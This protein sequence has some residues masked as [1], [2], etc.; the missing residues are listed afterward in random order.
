MKDPIRKGAWIASTKKHL[1]RLQYSP[2]VAEFPATEI[3][4]K[5]ANLLALLQADEA[6]RLSVESLKAYF[7]AAKIRAG[8]RETVLRKLHEEERIEVLKAGDRIEGVEV[9]TFSR[10]EVLNTAARIFDGADPT[11]REVA[12]I[13]ALEHVCNLPRT[14]SE[15]MDHLTS[16]GFEE[17]DAELTIGLQ[18]DLGLVGVD[19]NPALDE[20]IVFNEHAFIRNPTK[21][22]AALKALS[23][24]QRQTLVD[25]QQYVETRGCVM[26][27]DLEKHF[28]LDILR[29]MEELGL[30]DRQEVVSSFGNARFATLPQTF[31]VYGGKLGM[32]VDC[33]HHAKMLLSCLTYGTLRSVWH[34]GKINDPIA[35]IN[36]LLRGNEVGPCTAIGEDY[37]VLER[38]GV[39]SLR[40]AEHKPGK[41]YHMRLRKREVGE[42]AKQVF[43]YKRTISDTVVFALPNPS[44]ADDYVNPQ[45]K[46][47]Q[48]QAANVGPVEKVRS[49][50]LTALR[51]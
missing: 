35:I 10:E 21:I 32:G 2:E 20:P 4:G 17:E 23:P 19:K 28:P 11:P 24:T 12:S 1:D 36:S 31:G 29:L 7:I 48:L 18:Q 43:L 34:R 6:E 30:L 51:T 15:L 46:R 9:Y 42:L 44:P 3:A 47:V 49:R 14:E 37:R 50:L 33:F 5:A 16:G 39:V 25:I 41:Q 22:H 40:W 45:D 13:E 38:E 26:Y 8:E 27:N